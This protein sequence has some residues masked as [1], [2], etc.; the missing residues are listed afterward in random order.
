MLSS[1]F[2][3]TI[4]LLII[5]PGPSFVVL[6]DNTVRHGRTA[7]LMTIAGSTTGLACW[8]TVSVLGIVAVLRSSGSVFLIF[9]LIGAAYLCWI[10]IAALRDAWRHRGQT[11]GDGD[12]ADVVEG[13]PP[14]WSCYRIGA[15]TSLTNPKM[16]AVY[17]A[18]LPQFLPPEGGNPGDAAMLAAVQ[19][20]LSALWYVIVVAVIGTVRGWL[21]RPWCRSGLGVLSGTVLIGLGVHTITLS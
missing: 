6:V 7:G 10:G 19:I 18:L 15:L 14:R 16:A 5:A 2:F 20:A 21:S 17:L 12:P 11:T 3:L 1:A 9:K 13:R 8:A 4:I